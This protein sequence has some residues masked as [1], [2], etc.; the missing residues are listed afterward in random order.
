MNSKKIIATVF[1]FTFLFSSVALAQDGRPRRGKRHQRMMQKAKALGISPETIKAIKQIMRQAKPEAKALRMAKR[2]AVLQYGKKSPE[3]RKARKASRVYKRITMAKVKKLLTPQQWKAVRRLIKKRR[4]PLHRVVARHA[5]ELGL[6]PA[7]V[8][9]MKAEARTSRVQMKLK[10][11][12]FHQAVDAYG[13]GSPQARLAQK[14]L[15]AQRKASRKAMAAYLTDHQKKQLRA[16]FKAKRKAR[17]EQRK[18]RR[19]SQI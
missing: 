15:R 2:Q 3:A 10:R 6:S 7:T 13:K 8:Q 4:P 18:A 17:R 1:T 5:T 19:S 16:I 12:A 9:A 14:D 11:K